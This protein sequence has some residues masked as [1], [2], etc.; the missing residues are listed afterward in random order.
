MQ[1]CRSSS[2][3]LVSLCHCLEHSYKV[4]L[5]G[6]WVL[7]VLKPQKST[8]RSAF[9]HTLARALCRKYQVCPLST[10]HCFPRRPR[11]RRRTLH[12][13]RLNSI[14]V[15]TSEPHT[16]TQYTPLFTSLCLGLF[17]TV[18]CNTEAVFV[19]QLN[20]EFK[21]ST[22]SKRLSRGPR[23]KRRRGF[24]SRFRHTRRRKPGP[25]RRKR[26]PRQM[27]RH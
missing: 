21:R 25:T 10:Q 7:S 15:R 4:V 26:K 17:R 23:W 2:A 24:R 13:T 20:H 19:V 12:S 22:T 27:L 3:S 1:L 14:P 18:S 11:R 5:S 8:M 6:L 16:S 9:S